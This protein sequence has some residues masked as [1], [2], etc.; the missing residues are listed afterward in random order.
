MI[1]NITQNTCIQMAKLNLN[2]QWN[3]Y[4]MERSIMSKIQLRLTSKQW[5]N[6]KSWQLIS[7]QNSRKFINSF[8]MPSNWSNHKHREHDSA[9]TR[10]RVYHCSQKHWYR[11]QSYNAIKDN[12]KQEYV[13][14]ARKAANNAHIICLNSPIVQLLQVRPNFTKGT[15]ESIAVNTV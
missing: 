8:L 3:V 10:S 2:F 5:N 1:N 14:S 7:T 13:G 11:P 15:F 9:S 12:M 6:I 4:N